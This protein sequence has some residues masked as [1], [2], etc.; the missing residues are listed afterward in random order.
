MSILKD[1][2]TK[3]GAIVAGEKATLLGWVGSHKGWLVT[4]V[5]SHV[6]GWV[7]GKML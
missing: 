4:T 6:L 3:A 1:L 2:E 5:V 7:L